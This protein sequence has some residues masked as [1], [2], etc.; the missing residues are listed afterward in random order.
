MSD[1]NNKHS[2]YIDYDGK[3]F[4][5]YP[6]SAIVCDILDH[7]NEGEIYIIGNSNTIPKR[8]A[9]S[10]CNPVEAY[11]VESDGVEYLIYSNDKADLFVEIALEK[12]YTNFIV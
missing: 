6:D 1:L 4:G 8:P 3:G 12:N 9:A 10:N 11:M 7:A 5:T 2:N